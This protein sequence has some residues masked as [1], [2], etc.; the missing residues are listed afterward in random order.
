MAVQMPEFE[1]PQFYETAI[2]MR[3]RGEEPDREFRFL[4]VPAAAIHE[5]NRHLLDDPPALL[6]E[7]GLAE[8]APLR[9]AQLPDAIF[10]LLMAEGLG[11]D[12]GAAPDLVSSPDL[13]ARLRDADP[14]AALFAEYLAFAEVVPFEQSK[15][16]VIALASLAMKSYGVVGTAA[17]LGAAIAPALGP[18]GAVA[19]MAV[20]P[21]A[22]LAVVVID[23]VGVAAGW[24]ASGR[25][26]EAIQAARR[27][28]TRLIHG[29]HPPKPGPGDKPAPT[30]PGSEARERTVEPAPPLLELPDEVKAAIRTLRERQP[31]PG[32]GET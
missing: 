1:V 12:A 25:T 17:G 5:A 18:H 23:S 2:V 10:T 30:V 26:A 16:T 11:D 8:P 14:D 15:A 13:L 4:C 27:G 31:S 24:V 22:V 21:G 32:T 9:V 29:P 6:S 19:Y 7:L 28:I 3:H 20:A